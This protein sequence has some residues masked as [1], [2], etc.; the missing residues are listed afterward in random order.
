MKDKGHALF[1][2]KTD[3]NGQITYHSGYGWKKA[4]A[5]T[6]LAQWQQYLTDFK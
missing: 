4:G 2:A 3:A 5:I 1:V 6:S